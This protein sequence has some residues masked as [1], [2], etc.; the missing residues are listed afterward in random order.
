VQRRLFSP[1][2]TVVC[3]L[4]ARTATRVTGAGVATIL[5]LDHGTVRFGDSADAGS[6]CGARSA[7]SPRRA[8]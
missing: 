2:T 5:V 6:D 4:V 8:S 3:S 1:G 7:S